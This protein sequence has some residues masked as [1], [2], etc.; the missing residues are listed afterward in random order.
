MFRLKA[1]ACLHGLERHPI[2][3]RRMTPAQSQRSSAENHSSFHLQYHTYVWRASAIEQCY[4]CF[5]FL[6]VLR[7]SHCSVGDCD[8]YRLCVYFHRQTLAVSVA[9]PRDRHK[10]VAASW[11]YWID[12]TTIVC[13]VP[14]TT[15]PAISATGSLEVCTKTIGLGTTVKS[16]LYGSA[17]FM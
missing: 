14:V 6:F 8:F 16:F 15:W 12:M 17:N 5:T 10:T 7:L 3:M 4:Q 9:L 13:A 11:H 2:E 1:S